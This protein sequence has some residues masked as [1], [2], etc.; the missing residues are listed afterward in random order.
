MVSLMRTLWRKLKK[1]LFMCSSSTVHSVTY[2]IYSYS[3]NFDDGFYSNPDDASRSF[4]ARFSIP[5][6]KPCEVVLS[7]DDIYN[8]S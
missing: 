7:D 5:F 3:H 4:S 1:E 2:D 6:S 8:S